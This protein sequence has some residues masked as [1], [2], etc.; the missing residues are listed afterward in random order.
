MRAEHKQDNLAIWDERAID[1]LSSPLYDLE[2][3]IAG[4]NSL[5]HIELQALGDIKGK[6]I[7]HLQCHFGQ[8]TLSLAQLGAKVIGMDFSENAI[9]KARELNDQLGLD[10]KF[11]CSDINELDKNLQGQFD[12][13]FTSYGVLKWLSDINRWG[14]IV[15]HFT[16][17]RGRFYIVEFHPY[18]YVFDY[19]NAEKITYTYFVDETPISYDEVGTYADPNSE[20]KVRRAHSWPHPTSRVINSL[21]RSG[22]NINDFTEYP[23]STIDC[24]PFVEKTGEQIYKHK[25]YAGMVPILYS[26]D[27][28]KK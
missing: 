14:E 16:K 9:D 7:L 21:I 2:S 8:D 28:T 12:I 13:V 5:H 20:S 17:P 11:V 19:D 26:I 6:T 4:R 23:Y 27:A 3:F 25:K 15:A 18:L 1:H 24:F 10:A 22:F